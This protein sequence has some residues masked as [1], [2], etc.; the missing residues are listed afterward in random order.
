LITVN[1]IFIGDFMQTGLMKFKYGEEIVTDFQERD[2]FYFISDPAG[3]VPSEEGG[4]RLAVWMP[5]TNARQGLLL[6]KSEV[7]FI[8]TLHPEMDEY[9]KKWKKMVKNTIENKTK[10]TAVN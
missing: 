5:Y 8:T 4:W 3:L 9:Y 7:W 2:G 6:P 10:E 1:N